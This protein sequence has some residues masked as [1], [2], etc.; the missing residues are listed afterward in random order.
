MFSRAKVYRFAARS[1]ANVYGLAVERP[2]ISLQ[3]ARSGL[4][5]GQIFVSRVG[6]SATDSDALKGDTARFARV[7]AIE[8]VRVTE[9]VTS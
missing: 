8:V 5:R 9:R 2:G 4:L 1:R 7:A 6:R 3:V